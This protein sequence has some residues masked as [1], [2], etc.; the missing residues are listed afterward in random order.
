MENWIKLATVLSKVT[1]YFK[2]LFSKRWKE[3]SG[4][5]WKNGPEQADK[6]IKKE[7]QLL[8]MLTKDQQQ[9]LS[10]GVISDW[11]ISLLCMLLLQTHW[12]NP[13]ACV[14]ENKLIKQLKNIRNEVMHNGT[15]QI[16]NEEF[17]RLWKEIL[18][19][20]RDLGEDVGEYDLIK[21]ISKYLLMDQSNCSF[22]V[23]VPDLQEVVF[24]KGFQVQ[25]NANQL[26]EEANQAYRDKKFEKAIELYTKTLQVVSLSNKEYAVLYSNR[27]AAFIET[28]NF[29]KAYQDAKL[30][31]QHYPN[32]F[33]VYYRKGIALHK[34]GKYKKAVSGIP[35]V[36]HMN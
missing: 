26:K 29:P 33:K 19:K 3:L 30:S 17:E 35:R 31:Q 23:E 21:T 13:M 28:G 24:R 34:L 20:L 12:I 6:F 4:T 1:E 14:Q 25:P 2:V 10:E 7:Q 22:S 16:S 9:I 8:N 5:D 11:D 27:S 18:E 36:I 15:M 32:W